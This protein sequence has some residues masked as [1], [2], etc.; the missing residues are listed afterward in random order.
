MT[1]AEYVQVKKGLVVAKQEKYRL[2]AICD[3]S[4]D[5]SGGL[6]FV[7]KPSTI[8]EPTFYLDAEGNEDPT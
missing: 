7:K 5:W 8:N 2:V 3:V 6:E 1:T 4:A